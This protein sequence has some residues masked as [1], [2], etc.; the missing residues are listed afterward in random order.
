MYKVISMYTKNTPYEEEIKE[1]G[2]SC[3]QFKVDYKFYPIVNLKDWVKNTQQKAT[4]IQ[5]ALDEFKC[6]LVWLDA[7]AVI[8]KKL[9]LFNQLTKDDDFD[10]CIHR[11]NYNSAERLEKNN[12]SHDYKNRDYRNKVSSFIKKLRHP[13]GEILSGTIYFKNSAQTKKLV[14]EWV[15]L[16]TQKS[17][18]DQRTLQEVIDGGSN[19]Y[20]VKQ[21]PESYVKIVSRDNDI[22]DVDNG[23]NYIVHKQ[24]SRTYRKTIQTY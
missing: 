15:E 21:L 14:G 22:A 3:D 10:I 6:D 23:N 4:V 5:E 16:N 18:W 7:D 1:L 2:H 8:L 24:L 19:G 11:A 13:K 17:E 9:E 12:L 20:V